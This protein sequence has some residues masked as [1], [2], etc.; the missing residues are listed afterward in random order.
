MSEKKHVEDM[1]DEECKQYFENMTDAEFLHWKWNHEE[2]VRAT[3]MYIHR[4]V[5]I[6]QNDGPTFRYC[7]EKCTFVI[8]EKDD[9]KD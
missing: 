2:L 1:T 5:N 6:P 3:P 7:R 8:M 4:K 9:G